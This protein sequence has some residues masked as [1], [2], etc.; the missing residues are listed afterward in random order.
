MNLPTEII[1]N[2]VN[3]LSKLP[4]I[5]KKSALRLAIHL[6]KQDH[7][8]V[9]QLSD[10]L[11]KMKKDTCYCKRCH[12]IAEEVFCKICKNSNRDQKT[13][14]VVENFQDVIAIE[15]TTQYLGMYHVL[16]GIIQ[17]VEGISPD[18][19]NVESL[20]LRIAEEKP[21]EIILA[22]NPSI[23]GDTT[24]YYLYKCMKAFDVHVTSISRGISFGTELEYTDELTLG[25]SIRSRIMFD[26]LMQ[27]K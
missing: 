13:I 5:G 17:P 11:V 7:V 3:Q 26:T 21:K 4:G 18:Q 2:A 23:Q 27:E 12:N 8:F 14:C 25:R 1:Q 24:M 16:G 22:I 10:S 15:N 19:L 20:L 6:L 9:E